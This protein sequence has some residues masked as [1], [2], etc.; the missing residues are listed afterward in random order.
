[1]FNLFLYIHMKACIWYFVCD[2]AKMWKPTNSWYYFNE[3]DGA[4]FSEEDPIPNKFLIALYNSVIMLKGNELGP[5]A[6]V[7]LIVGTFMLIFDLMIAANI[8][9]Q[10]NVFVQMSNRKSTEFQK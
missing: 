2:Y 5:R 3:T 8:F 1:M 9:A 4:K 10:M 6:D 7:E